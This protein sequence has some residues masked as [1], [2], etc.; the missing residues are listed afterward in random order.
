MIQAKTPSLAIRHCDDHFD[1]ENRVVAHIPPVLSFQFLSFFHPILT[2]RF[3]HFLCLT[4]GNRVREI[5]P[6]PSHSTTTLI[7]SAKTAAFFTSS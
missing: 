6:I 4:C 3:L 5:S 7:S 1:F 2:Q